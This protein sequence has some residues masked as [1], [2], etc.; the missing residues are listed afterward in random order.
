M[1]KS[2][3]MLCR[4]RCSWEKTLRIMK[5]SLVLLVFCG[6][7]L[8][9]SPTKGQNQ[10]VTLEVENA[11]ILD[12]FRQ[13]EETSNLGFFF[14]ND[15]L[16]LEKRY[17]LNL[18]NASV[19][20]VLNQVLDREDYDYQIVGE[21]VVVTK[22]SNGNAVSQQQASVSGIV[23]DTAGEPVPGVTVTIK[24]TTTGTITDMA[25][26][27]EIGEVPEQA[28]LMFSF[29]GMQTREI[30]VA[31]QRNINVVLE[32]EVL[33]LDEVVVVGYGTQK[34]INLTGAVSNLK[35]DELD[36]RPITNASTALQGKVAGVYALQNSGKPG[37]DGATINIR[38]VGTLNNSDPLVLIDGFP[39]SMN[40]VDARDI[41]SVSVLKDA[42]SSAIYGNRAANGVIV[43]KTKRGSDNKMTVT[44]NGY[45]GVQQATALPDV[46]NSVD[47]ATLYNEAAVN[48]GRQPEYTDEEIQLFRDGSD[49]QYPDIDYFDVYYDKAK[50]QNHRLNISGGAD[51]LHYAFMAG[52]LDQEGILVGTDYQK[53]DFRSNFD[54]FFLKDN[55]LRLSARLSGNRGE[56]MQ[57][58]NE[59]DTKW[60]ATTAPVWPLKNPEDQYIAVIG[61]R[62]FFGEVMSGSTT[63]ITRSN[64]NSQFEA[65][66]E[67]LDGLSAEATYGF[68]LVEANTNS[69][70]ANVLLAR[71]D[72]STKT[73]AS[74]LTERNNHEKQTLLNALL[75]YEKVFGLHDIKLLAGYSEEEFLWNWSS[76][77]RSNFVN[78]DQRVLNLGDPSTMQN[79]AGKYDLGMQ[80]VFGRINYIMNE[81]YLFEA[82]VRRDGSSRFG[83]GNKWGTFP[84]FSFG[85]IMTEEGF[86]QG[87]SWLSTMKLRAS[88]GQLGNQNINSHYAASS[89]L[90]SG[91]N[92]SLGGSLQ[93]G[94]AITSMSN[95]ETTWETTEQ[96][97]VGLD[98][99]IS[100]N[101]EVTMDYF[102]KNT[103]DI[104]MQVPIPITM[105]NLTP[106]YSNVGAVENSGFEFSGTYR[107]T[108]GSDLK[109][110]GTLNLAY[111]KNKV[112]DLNGRSPIINGVSANVEGEAINSFYG[113]KVDGVYQISD[114][115]WQN[116]SDPDIAHADRNYVLRDGVTSVSNYS[117]QPGDL[118]FKDLDGDNVVTMDDD[119][120]VIG[121]Q[122]P[123]WSY[124]LQLNA[125][126]KQFDLGMFFQGVKGIEGYTYYE[127]AA[128]FSNFSNSGTWWKG[129]W[130]PENPTN[131]MPRLTLDD[132]RNN[133]HSEFY[134]E[135]ASYLRLKNVEL[136]YTL[137]PHLTS[138]IGLNK[139]RIY[140]NIQNAF[141]ITD[142]KG[143]DPEQPVGET[144][145][146]AYPQVRIMTV[147]LNVNF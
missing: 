97:D 124:S 16:D 80:S 44:Y 6:L 2:R 69:F 98:M 57:P 88:W 19:E 64:F 134:M 65:E 141:T 3:M 7:T 30:P 12:V 131:S 42:A 26:R 55:K 11:T 79:D 95:K 129:R 137:S 94:V 130:T 17:S 50:I 132:F 86:M 21:N 5:I 113:Y 106:P 4:N 60:Y 62:N 32:E 52:Y 96:I 83:E 139:V 22:K 23:T 35:M 63:D 117:A 25:G 138:E 76:G 121:K 123:D 28:T 118:K 112:T 103:T 53:A 136:G 70:N 43:I 59:W 37:D 90:N 56:Q 89:I 92:Y 135:D 48:S 75:R 81:R 115:T 110:S 146:Q 61:E 10:S 126:W 102:K 145:A 147:G 144:R 105:G 9:A 77:Y 101:I 109:L 58:T 84:S 41:E 85:W 47:Y 143:F 15:Q 125:E 114:F 51:N 133:I 87:I 67:I 39:G 14:K 34:K 93:S 120:T 100:K 108:I 140:G 13:I 24:G 40:D 38:G 72:G 8:S 31:G 66:F 45:T 127:V 71:M 68:N 20:E 107:K 82:N 142:F 116:S 119:R 128:P 73:L 46:F 1:K 33:G 104:L 49:W 36:S 78:N 99:V 29:I 111:M 18:K 91:Y 54:A 122:F 27:Y 74:G